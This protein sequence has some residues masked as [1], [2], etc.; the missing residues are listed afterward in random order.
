MLNTLVDNVLSDADLDIFQ[1]GGG[2]EEENFE[3]YMFDDT[4][5]NAL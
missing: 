1:R 5:I 2:V 4:R 3:I